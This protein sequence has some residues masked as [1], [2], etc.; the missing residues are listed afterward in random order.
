LTTVPLAT[1]VTGLSIGTSMTPFTISASLLA[2]LQPAAG[3]Y[4]SCPL[5]HNETWLRAFTGSAGLPI[6]KSSFAS[7]TEVR[8][9]L[10]ASGG[11]A[12]RTMRVL[13]AESSSDHGCE[14]NIC[15]VRFVAEKGSW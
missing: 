12:Y 8:S 3:T 10:V 15:S 14:C 11:I 6:P 13:H 2:Q 7:S 9:L 5:E 4:W 1:P